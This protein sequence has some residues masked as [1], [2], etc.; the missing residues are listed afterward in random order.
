M[1]KYWFSNKKQKKCIVPFEHISQEVARVYR[2]EDANIKFKQ[3]V[4]DD[5]RALENVQHSL[6]TMLMACRQGNEIVLDEEDCK[7]L[8]ELATKQIQL[9]FSKKGDDE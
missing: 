6:F 9:D 5:C 4:L 7:F 2:L 1:S 3:E 8:Y